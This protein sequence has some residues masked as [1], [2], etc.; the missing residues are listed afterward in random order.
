VDSHGEGWDNHLGRLREYL[1]RAR[2][3]PARR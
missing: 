2:T 3:Q 1:S